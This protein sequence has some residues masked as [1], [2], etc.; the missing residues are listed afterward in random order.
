MATFE[1]SSVT[2]PS[3]PG[4]MKPAVEWIRSPRR[5]REL[6]PSSLATRS[7]GS[8]TRSSVE[9]STNSPGWRMNAVS[10]SISTSSVSSSCSGFDVDERV[11]GVAEDPE[12][13]VDA[14]VDAGRLH[15]RIVVRLD[16]DSPLA[17]QA[18]DRPVGE[19]HARD[20]MASLA[21]GGFPHG[22]SCEREVFHIAFP[23]PCR[24]CS[25]RWSRTS[26]S[27]RGVRTRGE[28]AG[29][30]VQSS[31][32]CCWGDCQPRRRRAV[33]DRGRRGHE[34][35]RGQ[36]RARRGRSRSR[37]RRQRCR[38]RARCR[39]RSAGST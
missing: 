37:P 22:S 31:S 2:C 30:A 6:L 7:S 33:R 29:D 36:A 38:H 35:R 18:S 34:R 9:P 8:F 3:Q 27:V 21:A 1:S 20:S 25:S 4:S 10:S 16:L 12:I 15:Q 39:T 5:P 13:A 28:D 14:D 11:A 32:A 23:R 17:E 24:C 19:D 26:A